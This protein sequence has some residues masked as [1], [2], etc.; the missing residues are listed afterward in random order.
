M[1]FSSLSNPSLCLQNEVNRIL[2]TQFSVFS[3]QFAPSQSQSFIKIKQ[4]DQIEGSL[5]IKNQSCEPTVNHNVK[6]WQ[7]YE[8]S[9]FW[10]WELDHTRTELTSDNIK[11]LDTLN[12][13][14]LDTYKQLKAVARLNN[15]DVTKEE[16]YEEL[17][18]P[19]RHEKVK[20]WDELQSRYK[21]SY[22]CKYEGC[23]KHFNK[24]WNLLDH[25]RMHEGIKPFVCSIWAKSFTQKGNLKKH[26]IVQHS[27]DSLQQRK[28]HKWDYW[29]KAY[30]ERYNLV[31]S[32]RIRLELL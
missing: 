23:D 30:T 3:N 25:V 5:L 29:D 21:I 6:D 2:S 17:L 8:L 1:N 24:T 12:W 28:K 18:K 15:P 10:F 27:L 31:V 20:Q 19:F 9:R 13:Q 22:V 11:D 14:Q 4:K 32:L 7:R 16:I 26:N